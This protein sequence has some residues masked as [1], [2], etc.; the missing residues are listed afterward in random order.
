[1]KRKIFSKLLMG[2]FL[3]ASVS[4]FV[5]CKDYDDD[6]SKNS[7]DIQK[8]QTELASLKSSLTSDL[9]A[10]KSQ[11]ANK[12]N[13]EDVTSLAARVVALE[14][15][16]KAIDN[17]VGKSDFDELKAT[18][19]ALTGEVAAKATQDDIAKAVEAQN[20]IQAD[21]L[22]AFKKEVEA[23]GYL[24]GDALKTLQDDIADVKDKLSKIDVNAAIEELQK[25][26]QETLDELT[27]K[28]DE[29]IAT[30]TLFVTGKLTSVVLK[31]DFY[32][33]GIEGIEV[34]MLHTPIF[35]PVGKYTFS[36]A[37]N[38]GEGKIKGDQLVKVVVDEVMAAP[39]KN[40]IGS[41]EY[42]VLETSDGN[43]IIGNGKNQGY[44]DNGKQYSL[45]KNWTA[46]KGGDVDDVLSMKI[47]DIEA[48]ANQIW[49]D[50]KAKNHGTLTYVDIMENP[51]IN[52]HINPRTA[53]IEN[54]EIVFYENDAKVYT[55]NG[56][57]LI[58]P[59][60][61]SA[62]YT[63]AGED[64]SDP[65]HTNIYNKTTGILSVP[66]TCDW[67]Q[68]YTMFHKW[69][70]DNNTGANRYEGWT[71]EPDWGEDTGCKATNGGNRQDAYGTSNYP[72][73]G[74]G[75]A[76]L[77][78]V[79]VQLTT[80]DTLVTSDYGVIVPAKIHIV[81][82]ADKAPD[83]DLDAGTFINN[84]TGGNWKK[85]G[86]GHIRNNHLYE[87]VG[88]TNSTDK[89]GAGSEWDTGSYGAIPMPAT[90]AVVYNGTIN[91]NDF[92]E[93]HYSYTTYTNYGQSNNDSQV[94]TPDMMKAMGLR[95]EFTPINYIK[96]TNVTGESVHIEEIEEGVF[97]PRSVNADGTQIS[98]QVAT[99][100]VIDR[101]PLIRVDLVDS[102]DNIIRYGYIKLR[103]TDTIADDM[104]ITVEFPD[105]YMNCG[106]SVRMT[107]SQ[108]EN[109]ILAKLNDGKGMTK[110][111]FENSYYMEN[112]KGYEIMPAQRTQDYIKRDKTAAVAEKG[113]LYNDAAANQW[114]ATR[115][116]Q[117]ADGTFALSM[118]K[119]TEDSA[120]GFTGYYTEESADKANEEHSIYDAEGE[121]VSYTA[122]WSKVKAGDEMPADANAKGSSFTADNNWFG[123]VWY[124]PHYNSTDPQAWDEQ[125]NVIVWDILPYIQGN[126]NKARYE[127]LM[128]KV[129]VDASNKDYKFDG[130]ST[131]DLKTTIR[132]R[133]KTTGKSVYVT[134]VIPA[135]K[136]HFNYG[137]V[138]NKDWSHWFKFNGSL[139]G[140]GYHNGIEGASSTEA[141]FWEEFDTHVNP[142]KPSNVNYVY[143]DPTSLTQRLT[144]YWLNPSNMVLMKGG[145]N[146]S[147][148][149]ADPGN[150]KKEEG[151]GASK[152]TAT[153]PDITFIF[154]YPE[155]GLNSEG[156]TAAKKNIPAY[157]VNNKEVYPKM[158]GVMCWDVKGASGTVWTLTISNHGTFKK[159]AGNT[160]IWAVG[161]N[162]AAY[163]AEEVAYL[164]DTNK[165]PNAKKA[166]NT[167]IHYRGLEAAP[168]EQLYPAATDLINLSGAYDAQGNERFT[169]GGGLAGIATA[170]YLEKNVDETF[171]AYIKLNVSHDC[172]DPIVAKQYF[173]VRFYRPI[174]VAGLEIEWY[175]RV[176]A[177]N[178]IDIKDLVEIVDWNDFAVVSYGS[179]NVKERNTVFGIERP[180]YADVYNNKTSMKATNA[181]IP[182]EYYGIYELAVR[183]D[184]IRT[185]H[186][187]EVAVRNNVYYGDEAIESHTKLVKG[188]PSLSSDREAPTADGIKYKTLTLL[189]A[190]KNNPDG[191]LIVPFDKDHAYAHSDLNA[192][193]NGTKFG[194]IYYNNDAGTVQ[195]FHIYVPIA[196]KYNWGNI[197]WDDRV[198]DNTDNTRKLDKDYTQKV[199][200]VITV[201]A[202]HKK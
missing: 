80:K 14:T 63:K 33:E 21:A 59:A 116:Y 74:Q 107:W 200:A 110:Q 103:I 111:E 70:Y 142:H 24:T 128:K 1:M 183:Y 124:T 109:L 144:D 158:D 156:T 75:V 95:Y 129:G 136:L 190:D 72:N 161:K 133:H 38:D 13:A 15:Q 44:R 12:A 34:P 29:K 93:T 77:P 85:W 96:G 98:G 83:T 147:M 27:Q 168:Y 119:K 60:A 132:F 181:G 139:W 192:S 185:D 22:D 130:A 32:W 25:K 146:F 6:I 84:H 182:F 135:T 37:V 171:T 126:M 176:L 71:V 170:E 131:K 143:L 138:G 149:K 42:L 47:E 199:W 189:N 94:M 81:A 20:K 120:Y 11:L 101:E 196:V 193:G 10:A 67:D 39:L 194:K 148:F 102:N 3:I 125:T 173:N 113:T 114:W 7:A 186:A 174:N 31:P 58:K 78:F 162:G 154:T 43:E 197:K 9:D 163:P 40:K 35:K 134:L 56:T 66:F 5:S 106:T 118:G 48:E 53:D 62:T 195:L 112:Q 30:M 82:L 169:R 23:K 164:D 152:I 166:T 57:D 50:V 117:K 61:V 68:V 65:H 153:A 69:A 73:V 51:I 159:N 150:A 141:P 184:E 88:Y 140:G 178:T 46:L 52:Y 151:T 76:P 55:R 145:D 108:V 92:V 17:L 191:T 8:L 19:A 28:V 4:M 87:T 188:R 89:T 121:F 180:K 115:Y 2:A 100:E 45:W 123:R 26:S 179:T 198:T 187:E 41:C 36:Y 175:D 104:A 86:D 155:D 165:D 49:K 54:A 79:A 16:I 64:A 97:A 160:A 201:N 90:H 122:G 127:T 167:V 18:V 99:R 105:Q 91:L 177:D 202:T 137:E 172:Y 157:K